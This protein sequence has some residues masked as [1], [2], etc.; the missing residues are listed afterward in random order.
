MDEDDL[1]H[2]HGARL[3]VDPTH[4]KPEPW[5][6]GNGTGLMIGV[7]VICGVLTVLCAALM[8]WMAQ[9]VWHWG[10]RQTAAASFVAP[11]GL[12]PL[13]P[14]RLPAV[15]RSKAGAPVKGNP[16]AAFGSD[17]YPLE[18]LRRNEQGRT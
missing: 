6:V 18:A 11:G 4:P 16:G 7:L 10:Q 3:S 2:R 1:L 5:F 8:L 17:S 12:K 14:N 9:E 13:P 15:D